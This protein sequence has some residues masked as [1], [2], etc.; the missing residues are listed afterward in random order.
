M[1]RR[2][3]AKKP[4]KIS[5]THYPNLRV[6]PDIVELEEEVLELYPV[7]YYITI[8]R[9]TIHRVSI[10]GIGV[11]KPE[12]MSRYQEIE[13]E[14]KI[15]KGICQMYLDDLENN[16]VNQDIIGDINPKTKDRF[17]AELN[18]YIKYWT[19]SVASELW[20]LVHYGIKL[21]IEEKM[22]SVLNWEGLSEEEQMR[23]T[24]S[25]ELN[26]GDFLERGDYIFL[27]NNTEGEDKDLLYAWYLIEFLD[28]F[29]VFGEL[30]LTRYTLEKEIK[31][32][33]ILEGIQ[34]NREEIKRW[35]GS[36]K[37]ASI[38]REE[39]TRIIE[40]VR[41]W[42]KKTL[43]DDRK[44]LKLLNRSRENRGLE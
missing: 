16:R 11:E 2:A 39:C 32:E 24:I 18:A 41:Y 29:G 10:T 4:S 28:R 43:S 19:D 36:E 23:M 14:T 42:Q 12:D 37:L 44:L 6:K 8:K 13:D 33:A 21:S 34:K 31:I 26:V 30:L 3:R 17:V 38:T 1:E 20:C 27:E 40:L 35:F 15:I 5:V 25:V 7:Y 22:S 9:R